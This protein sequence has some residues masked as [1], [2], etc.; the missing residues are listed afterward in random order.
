MKKLYLFV[1]LSLFS[2]TSQAAGQFDGIYMISIN[3]SVTNYVTLH[4]NA[5]TSQMIAA[6]IDPDPDTTWMALSG[7]RI[8][9]T[10]TFATIAGAS[11]MDISLNIRAD[12]NSNNPNPTATI[13]SCVDGVNYSCRFPAGTTLNMIKIF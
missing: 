10:A 6:I 5:N 13:I 2:I 12:F 4:E 9:N 8:G 7:T 3:G 11:A 1:L